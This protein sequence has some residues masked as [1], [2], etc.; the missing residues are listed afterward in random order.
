MLHRP[1]RHFSTKAERRFAPK[2]RG[3]LA[4][5]IIVFVVGETEAQATLRGQLRLMKCST[6]QPDCCIADPPPSLSPSAP[7]PPAH[8]LDQL[9]TQPAQWVRSAGAASPPLLLLQ[10][11]L[12][13]AL[14]LAGKS[15]P[16]MQLSSQ[17]T[18]AGSD[19]GEGHL[20][21]PAALSTAS[22]VT[23][24]A[25]GELTPLGGCGYHAH[26]WIPTNFLG[27]V[28]GFTLQLLQGCFPK[29]T[30]PSC[31]QEQGKPCPGS[32]HPLPI[33]AIPFLV[34]AALEFADTI[35]TSPVEQDLGTRCSQG[36]FL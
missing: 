35:T 24:A 1:P 20:P 33:P 34:R 32:P 27:E 5:K 4:C 18:L 22:Q 28:P 26:T 12:S 2:K 16:D 21:S 7:A 30:A 36:S 10:Q 6:D 23:L 19:P 9:Q 13:F 8:P 17:L 11:D 3:K 25:G 29:P 15:I 14:S 31:Q